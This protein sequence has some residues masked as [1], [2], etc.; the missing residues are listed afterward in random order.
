M[1]KLLIFLKE[2]DGVTAIEYALIA[3]LI[4]LAI[5]GTVMALGGSVSQLYQKLVDD[6]P[7]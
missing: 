4:F 5:T 2:E 7:K 3:S 1:G 6:Y